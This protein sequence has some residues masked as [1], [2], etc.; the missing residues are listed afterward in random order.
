M[1]RLPS[2]L[3][4]D[5]ERADHERPDH[6]RGASLALVALSLAGLIGLAA[7]VVDVGHGRLTRQTLIPATDAAALAAAQDL[8]E[9]PGNE[10]AACATAGTY[11]AGNADGATMTGCVVAPSG[12]DAGRVTVTATETVD[13]T[14]APPGSDDARAIRS[15]SSAA[16]G[17]PRTVS[18]LRPLAF[19]YD[20]SAALRQLIDNPPAVPTTV[21]VRFVPDNPSACGSSTAGNFTTVA[22]QSGAS[23]RR[24]R[25]WVRNGYPQQVGLAAPTASDC[26]APELCYERVDALTDIGSALGSLEDRHSYVTFP[27][28]DFADA[29]AVHLVGV[30]RAQVASFLLDGL[31]DGWFVELTIEP[32]LIT[33]TCCGSPGIPAGNQVIALCGVDPDA[34][35]RCEPDTGP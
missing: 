31:P 2:L 19:C 33:G 3:R 26:D 22:F 20:G 15:V 4:P 21:A 14:F 5:P 32:G 9:A 16:F 30:I 10:Q 6:E 18:R 11:L 12:P 1:S 27:V 23:L 29:T 34:V 35:A 24:I 17:P 8:V 28:F 7:M 13:A 25:R